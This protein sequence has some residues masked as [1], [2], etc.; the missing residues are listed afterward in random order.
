M[1]RP[2]DA[3]TGEIDYDLA[4]AL[5]AEDL[6]EQGLRLLYTEDVAPALAER[7]VTPASLQE[8][9][10]T[11]TGRYVVEANGV[12]YQIAG[13]TIDEADSWGNA[14]FALFDIVNRQLV[15][16]DFT[17]YALNGGNDLFGIFMSPDDAER[18]RRALPRKTDWPCIVTPEPRWNGAYHD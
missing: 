2:V 16:M 14:T 17:F 10:D 6:A 4:I 18:A 8:D 15:E 9:I 1:R 7:G 11:T 5:D 3:D 13:P 12:R